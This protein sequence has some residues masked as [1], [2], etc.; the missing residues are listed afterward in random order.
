[1][2]LGRLSVFRGLNEAEWEALCDG[3]GRCCLFKLEDE[4]SGEIAF[5]RVACRLLDTHTCRCREYAR[6]KVLAPECLRIRE[7]KVS[8]LHWLP[9][10][11]AY[12]L[13]AL[14]QPLPEWHPLRS[15]NPDSVRLAGIAVGG[16]AV[17]ELEAGD[18]E[19]YII[20]DWDA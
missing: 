18:L 7:M 20:E 10:T 13:L 4:D 2:K 5:T 6:R 16:Y 19:D 12:R 1:M 15:G 11:C 14:G 17:S 9:P 8:Q 3:C